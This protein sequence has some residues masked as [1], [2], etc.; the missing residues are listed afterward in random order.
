MNVVRAVKYYDIS[1]AENKIGVRRDEFSI[2]IS[3]SQGE[4]TRIVST[5]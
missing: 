1:I 5:A 3:N 4:E 2:S